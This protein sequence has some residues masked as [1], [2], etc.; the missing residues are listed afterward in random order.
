MKVHHG[1]PD[2]DVSS[3]IPDS[4]VLVSFQ[5]FYTVYKHKSTNNIRV[6]GPKFPMEN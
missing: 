6:K 4:I 1:V 3:C 2:Y 5:I